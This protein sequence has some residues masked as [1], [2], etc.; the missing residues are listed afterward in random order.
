MGPKKGTVSSSQ[1]TNKYNSIIKHV[2]QDKS[3]LFHRIIFYGICYKFYA[4]RLDP[5]QMLWS[6]ATDQG[7]HCLHMTMSFLWVAGH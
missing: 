7:L 3:G 5:D 4:A 1:I 6:V 2:S